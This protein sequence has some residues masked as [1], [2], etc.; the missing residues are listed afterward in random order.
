ML[1]R[2]VTSVNLFYSCYSKQIMAVNYK[3]RISCCFCCI[4][5]RRKKFNYFIYIW[6]IIDCNNHK[7]CDLCCLFLQLLAYQFSIFLFWKYYI[8]MIHFYGTYRYYEIICNDFNSYSSEF[9]YVLLSYYFVI[10]FI[11]NSF[12]CFFS[13]SFAKYE[14]S[15]QDPKASHFWWP[16]MAAQFV[17]LIPT[18]RWMTVSSWKLQRRKF[19][20]I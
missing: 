3:S 11:R 17:I 15:K 4:S 7:K 12:S 9:Y 2:T 20:T 5:S 14:R 1:L 19:S 8:V 16:T 13:I 10:P 18:S 6:D